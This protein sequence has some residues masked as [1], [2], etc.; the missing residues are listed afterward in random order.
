GDGLAIE[1]LAEE[2]QRIQGHGAD[3]RWIA[4]KG[5]VPRVRYV[6]SHSRARRAYSPELL[7]DANE[8]VRSLAQVLEHMVEKNL[9][10]ARIRPGPRETLEVHQ[11]VRLEQRGLVRVDPTRETL[12]TAAQVELQNGPRSQRS[13]WSKRSR[14][15]KGSLSTT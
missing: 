3:V 4:E 12:R 15:Q 8:A 10:G 13:S 2:R 5:L 7:H 14:P 1:G 6:H 9:V 11:L